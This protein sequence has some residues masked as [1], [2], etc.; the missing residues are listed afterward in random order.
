MFNLY[1]SLKG[2]MYLFKIQKIEDQ[3]VEWI[4]VAHKKSTN[5]RKFVIGCLSSEAT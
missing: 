1:M 2:F 3:K 4:Y 5:K